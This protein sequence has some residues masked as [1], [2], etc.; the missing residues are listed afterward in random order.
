MATVPS[1]APARCTID[2][3]TVPSFRLIGNAETLPFGLGMPGMKRRIIVS[4]D[5]ASRSLGLYTPGYAYPCSV[6]YA[7]AVVNLISQP[8]PSTVPALRVRLA[9]GG[10]CSDFRRWFS[11]RS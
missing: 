11:A 6:T 8:H 7:R 2:V 1:H 4:H 5:T 9:A 10:N 3:P